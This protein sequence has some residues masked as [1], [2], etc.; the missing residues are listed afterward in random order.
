MVDLFLLSL[1]GA[2]DSS[3]LSPFRSSPS[4]L[5]CPPLTYFAMS[6]TFLEMS[7]VESSYGDQEISLSVERVLRGEVFFAIPPSIVNFSPC[8]GPVPDIHTMLTPSDLFLAPRVVPTFLRTSPERFTPSKQK[9]PPSPTSPV[10][11]VPLAFCQAQRPPCVS[12]V[13]HQLPWYQCWQVAHDQ[14]S[15]KSSQYRIPPSFP[16][17]RNDPGPFLRCGDPPFRSVRAAGMVYVVMGFPFLISTRSVI[18]SFPK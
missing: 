9:L 18:S 3:S 10:S 1:R 13:Q 16:P 11:G 5:I 14:F 15:R 2:W 17:N 12:F 7:R 8:A 4:V 6:A